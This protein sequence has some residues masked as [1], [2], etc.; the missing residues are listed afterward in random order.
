MS[1]QT[2]CSSQPII[3]NSSSYVRTISSIVMETAQEEI[4]IE[5][6]A[7]AFADIL[8]SVFSGLI[9]WE[10]SKAAL[11]GRHDYLEPTLDLAAELFFRGLT[12]KKQ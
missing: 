1:R 7:M 11:R 12:C 8:W 5:G 4:T 9:I 2:D 10:E 6:H 3:R